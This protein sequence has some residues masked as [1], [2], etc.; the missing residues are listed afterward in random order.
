MYRSPNS[1]DGNN[2]DLNKL[3]MKVAD[4]KNY[5]YVLL[6]G[7]GNYRHINWH[8]ATC[9][10]SENSKDFRFLESLKDSFLEQHIRE[11]T[12]GRGTDLPS[13]LD[14]VIT[15]NDNVIENIDIEAPLG[16]SDHA[17]I[18]GSLVCQF[19]PK[20]IKKTR[21]VYDKA[22][23]MKLK[24]M[25]PRNWNN[26]LENSGQ[27]TN[28]MWC[29]FR[30]KITE[31]VDKCVPKKTVTLNCRKRTGKSLTKKHSPK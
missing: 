21:Y 31:A 20:A 11:P 23:Y 30:N 27:N 5:D 6:T 29:T 4:E 14:L 17:V 26:E 10:L 8:L 13:T 2:E 15:K 28:E 19:Q 7:D 1:G 12:R 22:D 9:S 24:T 25:I 16:K 3:L 18:Q